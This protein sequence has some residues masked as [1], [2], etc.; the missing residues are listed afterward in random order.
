MPYPPAPAGRRSTA[1]AAHACRFAIRP[2]A[3]GWS[4]YAPA[5][6]DDLFGFVLRPNP[7]V[8][9]REVY[10][11]KAARWQARPRLVVSPGPNAVRWAPR[12]GPSATMS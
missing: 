9:P 11:T 4:V 1:Y 8:A 2:E 12:P 7:V 3:D 6:Y 5:G 10:E